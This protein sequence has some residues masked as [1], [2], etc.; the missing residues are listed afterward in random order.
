MVL[1]RGVHYGTLYKLLGSTTIDECNNFVV[2]E[3][4]GKDD[5]TLTALGE[6]TM[7][8]HQI[9]GHIEENGL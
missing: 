1:I 2:P 8:W 7:L 3:G 9:L 5:N 4:G 6:N